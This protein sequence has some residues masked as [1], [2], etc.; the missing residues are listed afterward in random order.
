MTLSHIGFSNPSPTLGERVRMALAEVGAIHI[1]VVD[2]GPDA[3]TS[4]VTF[5]SLGDID[6]LWRAREITDPR[7]LCRR[8]FDYPASRALSLCVAHRPLTLDCGGA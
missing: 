6:L 5:G 7:P 3:W 4:N 8:H 2:R 1:E